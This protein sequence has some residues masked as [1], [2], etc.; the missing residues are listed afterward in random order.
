[1]L[2]FEDFGA[3]FKAA[4][5]NLLCG[6]L[7]V[8]GTAFLLFPRTNAARYPKAKRLASGIVALLSGGVLLPSIAVALERILSWPSWSEVAK[9]LSIAVVVVAVFAVS[10]AVLLRLSGVDVAPARPPGPTPGVGAPVAAAPGYPQQP[11]GAYPPA[12][13]A[14]PGQG[15]P[16][17]PVPGAA[18][19][20]WG[21]QQ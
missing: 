17:Q 16:G 8:V 15:A 1:M 18:P 19:P 3:R 5:P 7:G 6:G 12:G 9:Y 21:G 10:F 11:P 2:T 13:Y 14:V 20:D 4:V